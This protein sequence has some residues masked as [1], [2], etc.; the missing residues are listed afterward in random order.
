MN[1]ETILVMNKENNEIKQLITITK[2]QI[3]LL[4]MGLPIFANQT[5]ANVLKK[6]EM[7][8]SVDKHVFTLSKENYT[9]KEA[10]KIV[11][12]ANK[13]FKELLKEMDKK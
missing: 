9:I 12:K 10:T 2:T 7:S 4:M 6:V 5:N 1:D 11:N 3:G 13:E 8:I